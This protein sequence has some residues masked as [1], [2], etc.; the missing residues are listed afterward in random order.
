MHVAVEL[1]EYGDFDS[2]TEA[3]RWLMQE[4]DRS[5]EEIVRCKDC[6]RFKPQGTY[7]F[8]CGVVNKD[9]CEVIRGYVVQINPDGFCAWGEKREREYTEVRNQWS[10]NDVTFSEKMEGRSSDERKQ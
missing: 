3:F 4:R 9:T 6:K 8:D 10:V 5:S 7:R 1:C 2:V